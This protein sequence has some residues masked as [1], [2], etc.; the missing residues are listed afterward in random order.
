VL[1]SDVDQAT[2][3]KSVGHDL[4]EGK[5]TLP[6]LLACEADP[7]LGKYVRSHLGEG[8]V[9][10]QVAAEILERV[11]QAGGV[12]RARQK[13]RELAAESVESLDMLPESPYR[14][15]LRDLAQFA[16]DR[17]S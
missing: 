12:E 3:G 17:R 9:P 15:A 6:V 4:T 11:R 14:S 2:A 10:A 16:A 7:A 8:G 13:A 1:D 5:L